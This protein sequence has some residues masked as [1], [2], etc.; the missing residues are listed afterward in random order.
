M[1]DGRNRGRDR[2][3]ASRLSALGELCCQAALASNKPVID[4]SSAV[5]LPAGRTGSVFVA[6][7]SERVAGCD[8]FRIAYH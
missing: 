6:K 3:A 1:A 2:L 5:M 8:S 4:V 7:G